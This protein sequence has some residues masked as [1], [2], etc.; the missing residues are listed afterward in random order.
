[1]VAIGLKSFAPAEFWLILRRWINL[2][3]GPFLILAVS[4]PRPTR[5]LPSVERDR[6]GGSYV[7]PFGGT[8]SQSPGLARQLVGWS[9]ALLLLAAAAAFISLSYGFEQLISFES[10]DETVFLGWV[11]S[12]FRDAGAAGLVLCVVALGVWLVTRRRYPNVAVSV[13][14][15][16]FTAV[17]AMVLLA[18]AS[19]VSR[20]H[21]VSTERQ[22]AASFPL[23]ASWGQGRDV[24]RYES[25]LVAGPP[26]AGPRLNELKVPKVNRVVEV[27]APYLQ[28][29]AQVAQV[30]G[31]WRGARREGWYVNALLR[32]EDGIACQGFGLTPQG[33]AFSTEVDVRPSAPRSADQPDMVAIPVNVSRVTIEVASPGSTTILR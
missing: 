33:W 24:V 16:A 7:A 21:P 14:L 29:C 17:T 30:V 2:K 8:R 20:H 6:V 18:W 4:R 10:S 1:V 32:S 3:S 31:H 27:T 15:G 5:N 22:I 26:W 25:G 9:F 23:P 11:A 13:C 12:G 19:D 28:V